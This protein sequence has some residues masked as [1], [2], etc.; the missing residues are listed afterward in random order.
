MTSEAQPTATPTPAPVAA[1]T[2]D[3]LAN[4]RTYLAWIRTALAVMGVGFAVAKFATSG[5]ASVWLS[6]LTLLMGAGLG[7]FGTY[8]YF[9]VLDGLSDSDSF[10]PDQVGVVAL[11]LGIFLIALVYVIFLVY[12]HFH[13]D[14]H[15]L[16][17]MYDR[18]G[19]EAHFFAP[20]FSSEDNPTATSMQP[21]ADRRGAGPGHAV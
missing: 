19:E 13:E 21:V 16:S 17:A 1:K 10:H 15:G 3:F 7:G 12:Q 8:R 14:S 11:T 9:S 4:E 5:S 2:T 18:V 20:S 6:V